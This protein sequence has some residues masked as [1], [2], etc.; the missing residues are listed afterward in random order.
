M[1]CNWKCKFEKDVKFEFFKLF[2]RCNLKILNFV[3]FIEVCK[4]FIRK[5]DFGK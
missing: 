5:E 4:N 3:V 2:D 1:R